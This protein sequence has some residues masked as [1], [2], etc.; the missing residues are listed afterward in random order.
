MTPSEITYT[1]ADYPPGLV[2]IPTQEWMWTDCVEAFAF[3]PTAFPPGT[4]L[5]FGRAS[6]SAAWNRNRLTEDFLQDAPARGWEWI[7]YIDADM[8]PPPVTVARLLS[9]KVDC[10]GA[11]CY[12]RRQPHVPELHRFPDDPVW[13]NDESPLKSVV[14][15]GAG[16]LLVRRSVFEKLPYPW[17]EQANP[18]EGEDILFCRRLR[19][20]GIPVHCDLA[21]CIPQVT[22]HMITRQFAESYRASPEGKQAMAVATPG[23]NRYQQNGERVSAEAVRRTTDR[24]Q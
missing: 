7:L 4:G 21:L 13:R 24:Q 17:W 14:W 19:E 22:T 12:S 3:L 9:H 8:V 6:S 11:L 23:S 16:C 2:A 15:V 1:V 18:G 5:T 10:V 20:I